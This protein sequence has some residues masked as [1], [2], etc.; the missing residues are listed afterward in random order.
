MMGHHQEGKQKMMTR[1]ELIGAL[2]SLTE[3]QLDKI[4]ETAAQ[5]IE[6]NKI[7]PK[8]CPKCGSTCGGF[9]QKGFQRGKQRFACK[10]CGHKFTYDTLQ[11]TAHSHLP[12]VPWVALI[13]VTLKFIP[14]QVTAEQLQV[15]KTTVFYMRHRF[16]MSLME[17][18]DYKGSL[19]GIME[20]DKTYMF[21]SQKG[22]MLLIVNR[23]D[24]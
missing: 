18:P 11:L 13:S 23:E 2:N 16:L 7:E 8:S 4:T 15:N 3:H 21:E 22:K 17:M 5:Y 24:T 20:T 1:N 9:I 14:L 12:V 6:L 10:D 19:A